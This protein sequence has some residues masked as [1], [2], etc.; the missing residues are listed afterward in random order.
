MHHLKFSLVIALLG[1]TVLS[2][3]SSSGGSSSSPSYSMHATIGTTTLNGTACIAS[4]L[5]SDL[6]ISGST[7]TAGAGGPPQI[8]INV[9]PWSGATGTT[10]LVAPL[11]TGSFGEYTASA[12]TITKVSQTGS[13]TITAVSSTTITG[14]FS[15]TCSD[16]TGVSAGTFTAK[17]Y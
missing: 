5:G 1:F 4:L 11:P 15:F 16:G 9:S 6:G 8:N 7:V 14:T 17:R 12:G 2:G 10:S 3:C 13:V